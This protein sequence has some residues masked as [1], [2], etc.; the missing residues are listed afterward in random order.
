[1]KEGRNVDT[2]DLYENSDFFYKESYP[3]GGCVRPTAISVRSLSDYRSSEQ[4]FTSGASIEFFKILLGAK[5]TCRL[6]CWSGHTSSCLPTR[7]PAYNTIQY[8][9]MKGEVTDSK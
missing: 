1:M 9:Y 8:I 7:L 6:I 2:T 3:K 4:L 5:V